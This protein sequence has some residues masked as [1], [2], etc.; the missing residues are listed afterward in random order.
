MIIGTNLSWNNNMAFALYNTSEQQQKDFKEIF[1][2]KGNNEMFK[3]KL[4]RN[5]ITNFLAIWPLLF[6]QKRMQFKP[7]KRQLFCWTGG[8]EQ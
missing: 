5:W 1:S 7:I 6:K 3:G 2:G 4:I 8:Q